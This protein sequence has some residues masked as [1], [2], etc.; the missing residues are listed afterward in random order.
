[1]ADKG[2]QKKDDGKNGGSKRLTREEYDRL[3]QG[4]DGIFFGSLD[5]SECEKKPLPKK[6]S[7]ETPKSEGDGK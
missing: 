3:V 6:Q 2:D 5:E 4:V 7:D 1:M